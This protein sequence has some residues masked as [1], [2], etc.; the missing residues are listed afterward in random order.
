M[1]HTHVSIHGD[2]FLING[3]PTYEGRVYRGCRIEG[4]L[5]NTRMVQATFDDRNPETRPHWSYPDTGEWDPERNTREFIAAMSS[6]RD[7]GVLGF[8]INLQGGNPQGYSKEQPWHNSAFE[9]DGSLR[10]DYLGRLERI[11]D[12]ADELGMVVIVGVYLAAFSDLLR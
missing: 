3:R 6:W 9:A 12:R 7:H 10:A 2:Q 1:G 5:L 4:L 11:L 8:T